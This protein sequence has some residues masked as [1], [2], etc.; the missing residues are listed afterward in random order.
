ML[1][2][3]HCHQRK[4]IPKSVCNKN[5][6]HKAIQRSPI[7]LTDSD[8]DVIIDEIKG[9]DTIKYERKT[10]VNDRFE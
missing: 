3:H 5:Q 4:K 1:G 2:C 9:G 6:S 8:H 7:C 10:S